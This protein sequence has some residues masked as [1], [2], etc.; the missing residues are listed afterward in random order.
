MLSV[1]QHYKSTRQ[2][3]LLDM[4]RVNSDALPYSQK[5]GTVQL[6]FER[7]E[8]STPDFL[9]SS[10]VEITSSTD[11][12]NQ[13]SVKD[14]AT[15]EGHYSEDPHKHEL[16]T[17][18]TSSDNAVESVDHPTTETVCIDKPATQSSRSKTPRPISAPTKSLSSSVLISN[19][20]HTLPTSISG[21]DPKSM[22]KKQALLD[23]ERKRRSS[24]IQAN[25]QVLLKYSQ[26]RKYSRTG[27][28]PRE[29]QSLSQMFDLN[30]EVSSGDTKRAA[31]R[32]SSPD[33]AHSPN[34]S[35]S[36]TTGTDEDNSS[37]TPLNLRHISMDETRVASL[38]QMD[39]IWRQVESGDDS[40][41]P[42]SR[43][44]ESTIDFSS[45]L[46]PEVAE[47]VDCSDSGETEIISNGNVDSDQDGDSQDYILNHDTALTQDVI[48]ESEIIV[49][50][51][52][53]QS[54]SSVS[55]LKVPQ[56]SYGATI[57]N[58]NRERSTSF[59]NKGIISYCIQDSHKTI[60]M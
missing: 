14:E 26:E 37:S 12:L 33:L 19:K 53:T 18:Q 60:L 10:I 16:T 6:P 50:V 38:I 35:S 5:P 31:R 17:I 23:K 48:S 39:N 25:A 8:S 41:N 9:D 34:S 20:S 27:S 42:S 21:S 11:K 15:N 40:P 59:S 1:M 45:L 36:V 29:Y 51:T 58:E 54:T 43:V 7:S 22:H 56:L 4:S 55:K 46:A 32:T 52:D 30:D 2:H 47:S 24:S 44:D 13:E 3:D 49:S 57:M 28:L